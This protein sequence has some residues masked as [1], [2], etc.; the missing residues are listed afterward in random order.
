[1]LLYQTPALVACFF[2][3]GRELVVNCFF[4]ILAFPKLSPDL[5]RV[6]DAPE[7]V[8]L[9]GKG[10][11]VKSKYIL[12]LV[13][14]FEYNLASLKSL[15]CK[16]EGMGSSSAKLRGGSLFMN[17]GKLV[18]QESDMGQAPHVNINPF[19]PDSLF[20]QSSVGQCRRRKRTHW[21]K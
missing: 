15:L 11:I 10:G 3:R 2:P 14:G 12:A 7:C 18:K 1:M 13:L 5:P 17:V 20:L 21:N 6:V 16:A 4:A 8:G 9:E 19:T